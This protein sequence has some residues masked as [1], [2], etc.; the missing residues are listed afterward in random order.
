MARA[1]DSGVRI[2]AGRDLSSTFG[3]S[4]GPKNLPAQWRQ[5]AVSQQLK[6]P[7]YEPGQNR[8]WECVGLTSRPTYVLTAWW[9]RKLL[10]VSNPVVNSV[11]VLRTT[12][13]ATDTYIRGVSIWAC[14]NAAVC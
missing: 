4:L 1:E 12:G 11:P 7:E 10:L 14:L 13:L 2:L 9:M 8:L 6:R 3:Q 5:V